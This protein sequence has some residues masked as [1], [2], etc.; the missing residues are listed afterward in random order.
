MSEFKKVKLKNGVGEYVYPEIDPRDVGSSELDLMSLYFTY[1]EK[2]TGVPDEH[3]EV[4]LKKGALDTTDI[5]SKLS[6]MIDSMNQA[7]SLHI[8]QYT[9]IASFVN[10]KNYFNSTED[11][12]PDFVLPLF[13]AA[14]CSLVPIYA[15]SISYVNCTRIRDTE[16]TEWLM[17]TIM[18]AQMRG[19]WAADG[20]FIFYEI[21][22]T[23]INT[24]AEDPTPAYIIHNYN[25]EL[26]GSTVVPLIFEVNGVLE[27]SGEEPVA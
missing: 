22:A 14:V 6:D 4:I 23:F 11:S 7:M 17:P 24:F 27:D 2:V 18:P 16:G 15:K 25:S 20:S 26:T 8:P 5:V 10:I 19:S 1:P 12:V 9:G 21:A 3:V 13:Y